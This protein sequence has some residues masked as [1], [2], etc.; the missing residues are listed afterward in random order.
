MGLGESTRHGR[1][2]GRGKGEGG[3][4]GLGVGNIDL[5]LLYRLCEENGG[6]SCQVLLV[7]NGSGIKGFQDG[8]QEWGNG[9]HPNSFFMTLLK[10]FFQNVLGLPRRITDEGNVSKPFYNF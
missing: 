8:I 7:Q 3:E 1:G 2:R 6:K 9:P 5:Y 4:T 10:R